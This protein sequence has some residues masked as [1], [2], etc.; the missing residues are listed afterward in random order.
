VDYTLLDGKVLGGNGGEGV[1][2]EQIAFK[3]DK[4][5]TTKEDTSFI[6]IM[7]TATTYLRDP[8]N[9]AAGSEE[10]PEKI[11][12][13]DM[14]KVAVATGKKDDNQILVDHLNRQFNFAKPLVD[15]EDLWER[16]TEDGTDS[17]LND[18]IGKT[19]YFK[20]KK[21]NTKTG[22]KLSEYFF[23]LIALAKREEPKMSAVAGKMELIKKRK[24]EKAK[25]AEEANAAF[26][27]AGADPDIPF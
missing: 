5:P 10:L 20:A 22:E 9:P 7:G 13:K 17:I 27:T 19:I 26:A 1:M 8:W 21:S 23:N 24:A 2:I 25:A 15:N 6:E 18:L 4:D 12:V 16:F 3:F 14:V 11:P